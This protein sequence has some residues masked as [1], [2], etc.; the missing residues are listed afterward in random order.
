[1]AETPCPCKQKLTDGEKGILNFGLSNEMLKN[2]NSAAI[3]VARQLGQA[4]ASRLEGL[5]QSATVTT[6]PPGELSS[7]L[8]QALPQLQAAKTSVTQLQNTVTA[9]D[10]EC[11]RFTDP[12]QLVNI[13]SSL[14]LFG[15][16]SC[17]LGIEGLDIGGGLN[18]VN[19][20]G[21]LSINYAVAANV[22]LE[23]VLNQ[24][25]DGNL[26]TDLA[27][28]VEQLQSGLNTAFQALDAANAAIGDVVAKAAA[29]QNE[30]ANFIQKYTSINSLANLVNE[31]NTDPCFKLGSTL[32]G[33]L[34]SPQFIDAVR[35]N[36]IGF[37]TSAR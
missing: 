37:G 7:P 8:V 29:I 16:L 33:S 28:R 14:S 12:K 15:E 34:V 3:G 19:Q 17:A 35:G 23:K 27:G 6:S 9:F 25:S 18:V 24:F 11:N 21:Q 4:N 32:N 20:N 1:M 5:I 26:G 36:S 22:D 31:A 30:A 10:A 2:P 13:I